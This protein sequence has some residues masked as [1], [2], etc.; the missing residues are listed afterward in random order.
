M[1]DRVTALLAAWVAAAGRHARAVV[2][3]D[4]LVTV[5]LAA[6]AA[7]ALGVNMDNKRLIVE[8]L[9]FRQAAAE[10][11][12]YFPSLDDTLL[13]VVDGATPELARDGAARLAARLAARDDLFTDVWIP[14]AGTF[15]EEHGLLYRTADE[16]DDFVDHL[17][18]MQ[19][20]IADLSRDGS[21]AN[22]ARL[23]RLGLDQQREEGTDAAQWATILDRVGEATVRV[24][25]EHPVSISWEELMVAGSALDTGT[26]QVVV[27]EPVLAFGR[28]LAAGDAIAAIRAAAVEL[29]LTPAAGLRIRVTGNPA[30][31]HDEMIG[32]AWDVGFAGIFSFALVTGILYLAFRSLRLVS[33]AALTLLAGL[34]WT[35]GFATAT[36]G[37]LNVVSISFGVLFIGL[38]VDFAIHLGM[39]WVEEAARGSGTAAAFRTAV[40]GV[41]VSLVLCALTTALGFF[42]FIPTDYRGV[43]ELGLI[44]GAGMFII[45]VQTLTLFPAL[46]TLRFGPDPTPWLRP[47]L[48]LTLAPP[49][50]VARRPGTVVGAALLVGIAA[51]GLV[52]DAR[53]DANVVRMRDPRTESVEAFN[54]LLAHSRTS[55]W[56]ANVLAPSLDEARALAA[57]LEKEPAVEGTLT[58]ADYVPRNQ[59]EKLGILADAALL[60]DAPT[61]PRSG[62]GELTP[63]EQIAALRELAAALRQPWLETGTGPLAASARAL[64]TELER[65]LARVER[66][67][68]RAAAFAEL[69][70]VLLGTFPAQVARLKRGLASGPVTRADLPAD[71]RQRLL[72]PDG[73]A[74]VQVFPRADLSETDAFIGFVDAVRAIAPDATGVAVNLVEFARA[75]ERSL[76][77]ALLLAFLAI[78]ALLVLLWRRV[79]DTLFALA[80]LVLAGVLTVAAMVLLDLPFNFANVTALPLLL[81]IGV[82]SGIHLVHQSRVA[83]T[84]TLLDSTTARAV[85]FSAVTTIASFG[86]LGLSGH[87]GIATMGVLLVVGMVAMLACNLIVLPAMLALRARRAAPAS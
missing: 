60:M 59:D 19:P 78:T 30:L 46:V 82:D 80:P 12:R 37:Q 8:D 81:G 51:A 33:S 44:S 11:E 28:L 63:E 53:L 71:L 17:A 52:P 74:R 41:G 27:A 3:V 69:E 20:V 22:L 29:G 67:R 66:D 65:F 77:E 14:G 48:P 86:S 9:P 36:V 38:G 31:N 72:A 75:T 61:A 5:A 1:S 18:R 26:R 6:W 49:A 84:D 54:D 62:R 32:I 25:D 50:A 35:A 56:H 15:F 34:I 87:R 39:H 23:V 58:L 47:P 43:A 13:V 68:D 4:A 42:A 7:L 40:E 83:A 10:F 16:L 55:P 76:R 73:H 45:L 21:I 85:F 2:V 70:E 79:G 57:R 64:R 24:Y